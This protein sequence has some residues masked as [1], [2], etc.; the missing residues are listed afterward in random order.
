MDNKLNLLDSFQRNLFS[1]LNNYQPQMLKDDDVEEFIVQRANSAHSAYLQSSLRGEPHYLAMEEAN[2]VLHGGLEFSPV[3]FIQETYEE[4]KKE[5]LDVDKA[6]DIY[7]KAKGIFSQCSGDF[8]D[9]EE[10][11]KLKERLVSFFD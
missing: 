7:D 11:I 9:I 8:E 1:Y 5:V 4:K 2:T 6:L 3:S 10:E